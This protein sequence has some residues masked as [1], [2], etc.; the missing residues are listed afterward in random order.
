MS[1]QYMTPDE[2]AVVLRVHAETVKR[3]L[4]QKKLVGRKIGGLWRVPAGEVIAKKA[5]K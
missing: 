2:A 5:E 4:R 1:L 3:W